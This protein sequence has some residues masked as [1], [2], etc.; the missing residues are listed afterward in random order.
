MTD[1]TISE[2]AVQAAGLAI[3]KLSGELEM[4]RCVAYDREVSEALAKAAIA[5]ALPV[6][7]ETVG[8]VHPDTIKGL[9]AG[10]FSKA[11]FFPKP[12][13]QVWTDIPLYRIKEPK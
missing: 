7:F 9:R 1:F 8:Y 2:E 13:P 3:E 4:V 11:L 12:M 10:F 6:M 5:A